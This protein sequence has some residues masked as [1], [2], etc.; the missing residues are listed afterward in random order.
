[1]LLIACANLANLMLVRATARKQQILFGP[2]WE[3]HAALWY[4]RRLRERGVGMIG[5][6]AGIAIA[7]AATE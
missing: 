2:R 1:M 5:G 3:P 4:A 6:I 7:F